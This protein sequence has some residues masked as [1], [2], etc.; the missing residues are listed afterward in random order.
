[1]SSLEAA[2]RGK[3]GSRSNLRTQGKAHRGRRRSPRRA[4]EAAREGPAAKAKVSREG[5]SSEE[6]R[7][8][9]R[10]DALSPRRK[11]ED[12]D[13]REDQA[14]HLRALPRHQGLDR[15]HADTRV[16]APAGDRKG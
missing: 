14:S 12:G 4:R 9:L 15:R 7:Q 5:A 13:S 2:S 1:M 11:V 6:L 16:Y 8:G 3:R 10:G